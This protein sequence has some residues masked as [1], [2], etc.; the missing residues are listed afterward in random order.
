MPAGPEAYQ[1]SSEILTFRTDG[2]ILE[3]G[4]KTVNNQSFIKIHVHHILCEFCMHTHI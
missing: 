3:Q 1:Y 4:R 2:K